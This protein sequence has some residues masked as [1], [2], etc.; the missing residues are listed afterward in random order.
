[1]NTT[2]TT[3]FDGVKTVVSEPLRF[4]ARLSIGEDAYKKF[5]LIGKAREGWDLIGAAGTGAMLAKST[6]VAATFFAPSGLLGALG[7]ATAVTPVGWVIAAGVISAGAW[8]GLSRAHKKATADRV[9]VIP[10]YINTQ[11][12]VLAISLADLLLPLALK[13]A[14]ADGSI[15]DA[16]REHLS[17]YLVQE[18]GY[19]PLFV[20]Q[21]VATVEAG[22]DQLDVASVAKCLTLFSQANPDCRYEQM[23]LETLNL[24]REVMDVDERADLAELAVIQ[25]VEAIFESERPKT[26]VEKAADVVNHSA[27]HVTEKAEHLL[28]TA[29]TVGASTVQRMRTAAQFKRGGL[30]SRT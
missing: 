8:Y 7:L 27:G 22:L 29:R 6:V 5:R 15:D 25:E 9:L 19:D 30:A 14:K 2:T 16:E 11:L 1:M 12:D 20:S 13:V 23:T 3:M 18:W 24:L 28:T 26:V 21:A 4:K 10:R 17:T